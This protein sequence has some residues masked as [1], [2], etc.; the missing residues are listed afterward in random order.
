MLLRRSYG[1]TKH[2]MCLQLLT[3]FSGNT[4]RIYHRC[5]STSS[6]TKPAILLVNHGYPPLFNA[7]SEVK[8]KILFKKNNKKK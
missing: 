3:R 8:N 7:G 5:L 4:M 1:E 2:A 6:I